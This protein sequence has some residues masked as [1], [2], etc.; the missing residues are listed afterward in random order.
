MVIVGFASSGSSAPSSS[1][2]VSSSRLWSRLQRRPPPVEEASSVR[3]RETAAGSFV[4]SEPNSAPVRRLASS[5]VVLL[6]ATSACR[7]GLEEVRLPDAPEQGAATIDVTAHPTNADIRLGRDGEREPAR[8]AGSPARFHVKPGRYELL[9]SRSGE[10]PPWEDWKVEIDTVPS[11]VDVFDVRLRRSPKLSFTE[12][13]VA[14]LLGLF[15]LGSGAGT[16]L[17]IGEGFSNGRWSEGWQA[18][19]VSTFV[20]SAALD[21]AFAWVLKRQFRGDGPFVR[22]E[23]VRDVETPVPAP[24]R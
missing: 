14:V 9:V 15:T 1:S 2:S 16:V 11:A 6:L 24:N 19:F 21:V 3:S 18:V 22:Y 10:E 13:E 8:V 23:R 20:V 5:G 4:E 12:L 17:A 7:V